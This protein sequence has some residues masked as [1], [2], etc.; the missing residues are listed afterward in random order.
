MTKEVIHLSTLKLNIK[1]II[2]GTRE[3]AQ[4]LAAVT[5]LLE[6]PG[7]IPSPTW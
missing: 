2:I 1:K 6:D 5:A 4:S 3:I 7:L